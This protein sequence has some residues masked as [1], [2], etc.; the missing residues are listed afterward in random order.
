M[1]TVLATTHPLNT[2]PVAGQPS[3]LRPTFDSQ[4]IQLT[5]MS[6]PGSLGM[7]LAPEDPEQDPPHSTGPVDI[8]R[9]ERPVAARPAATA[10]PGA[11]ASRYSLHGAQ[12]TI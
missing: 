5:D 6:R 3:A 8:V 1:N 4:G 12:K 2:T 11:T 7:R 10:E 9:L